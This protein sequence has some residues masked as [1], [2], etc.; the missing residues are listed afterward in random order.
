[1]SVV[2]GGIH[3][4]LV[5]ETALA[6][7]YMD[8]IVTGEAEESAVKFAQA[9]REGHLPEEVPGADRAPDGAGLA[10]FLAAPA[11]FNR[12]LSWADRGVFRAPALLVQR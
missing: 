2:W 8:N 1:V 3:P 4:T 10:V 6:A 5:P 9:L 12:R 7:D 11:V